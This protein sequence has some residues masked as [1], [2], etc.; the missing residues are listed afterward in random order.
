MYEYQSEKRG[1]CGYHPSMVFS[2]H[3][4][5]VAVSLLHVS[6][7]I[8][9]VS[10]PPGDST[11]DLD[12]TSPFALELPENDTTALG[13][14]V[15]TTNSSA[16]LRASTNPSQNVSVVLPTNGRPASLGAGGNLWIEVWYIHHD[17]YFCRNMC[18]DVSW[19]GILC[20]FREVHLRRRR[21][22]KYL[23]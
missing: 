9:P 3:G 21:K 8:V 14:A 10:T 5:P 6:H 13:A 22:P 20:L 12:Y 1:I 11:A 23:W 4:L 15:G 2:S 16:I 19:F 7:R 17:G 18:S